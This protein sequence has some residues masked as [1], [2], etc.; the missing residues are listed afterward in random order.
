MKSA[1]W[2]W[3]RPHGRSVEHRR[4]VT[5][6]Y[7][8]ANEEVGFKGTMTLAGCGVL[9]GIFFLLILSAWLP[10]LGWLIVPLLACF[11][12]LQLFRWIIPGQKEEVE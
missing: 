12:V 10:R 8:E 2:S 9:W 1:V 4:A 3:T 5:L 7:Q 6:E 11:L